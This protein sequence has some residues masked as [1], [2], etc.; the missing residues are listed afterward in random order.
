MMASIP[1]FD[2]FCFLFDIF[3]A[4]NLPCDAKQGISLLAWLIFPG[5]NLDDITTSGTG[6]A[7][8]IILMSMPKD[9]IIQ[10]LKKKKGGRIHEKLQ[11]LQPRQKKYK[12]VKP[13]RAPFPNYK[14]HQE[15]KINKKNK[16]YSHS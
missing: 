11:H 3:R 6:N 15:A 10:C 8:V 13:L 2:L 12:C 4:V 16:T 5:E 7:T 1:S 9:P 14:M